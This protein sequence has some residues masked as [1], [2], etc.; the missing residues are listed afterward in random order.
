MRYD[1]AMET[2]AIIL[3]IG[4]WIYVIA[5]VAASGGARGEGTGWNEYES[6]AACKCP[7]AI[8]IKQIQGW[9]VQWNPACPVHRTPR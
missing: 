9:R 7:D 3:I 4:F 1:A 2:W 8:Y 5:G 6:L